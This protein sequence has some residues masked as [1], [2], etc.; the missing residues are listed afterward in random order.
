[1]IEFFIAV[2]FVLSWVFV[3]A[4]T[5]EESEDD[6]SYQGYRYIDKQQLIERRKR[7]EEKE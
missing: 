6:Y 7:L 5:H 4:A 3:A 2:G 1:M